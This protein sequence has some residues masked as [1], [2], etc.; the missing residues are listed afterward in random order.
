MLKMGQP[1]PASYTGP[2]P[3]LRQALTRPKVLAA[4]A[5][6]GGTAYATNEL[7][8]DPQMSVTPSAPLAYYP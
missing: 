3:K 8:K 7:S 2:F 4:G 6:L 1:A 5:L